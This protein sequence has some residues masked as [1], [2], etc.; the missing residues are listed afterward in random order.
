MRLLRASPPLV[1]LLFV[2]GCQKV[3]PLNY[4]RSLSL[5]AQ[6]SETITID[7][8]DAPRDIDVE[9]RGEK[10]AAYLVEGTPTVVVQSVGNGREPPEGTYFAKAEGGSG[11]VSFTLAKNRTLNVIVWNRDARRATADVK[12]ASKGK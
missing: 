9:I 4:S 8:M 1:L 7:P 3:A 5:A 6:A 11:P 10:V 12:I 2:V